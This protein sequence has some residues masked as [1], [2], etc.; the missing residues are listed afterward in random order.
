MTHIRNIRNCL[1]VLKNNLFE[2]TE[3]GYLYYADRFLTGSISARW[4]FNVLSRTIVIFNVRVFKKESKFK[5]WAQSQSEED[6][7]D[8]EMKTVDE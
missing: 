4:G 1:A 2:Y 6:L 3:K 8:K 7:G 5:V